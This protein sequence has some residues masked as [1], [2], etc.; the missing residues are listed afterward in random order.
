MG[1]L[2]GVEVVAGEEGEDA[3]EAGE[4]VDEEDEGDEFRGCAQGDEVEEGLRWGV[5]WWW[6]WKGGVGS[7]L[8]VWGSGGWAALWSRVRWRYIVRLS[9]R[10]AVSR[11]CSGGLS[12]VCKMVRVV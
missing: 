9:S 12:V 3:V 4:F 5:S 7:G 6:W 8:V 11:A 10:V 2:E 1:E